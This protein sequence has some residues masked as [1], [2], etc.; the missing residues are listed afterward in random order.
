MGIERKRRDAL[1]KIT[2]DLD[3]A[4][5]RIVY[6][7]QTAAGLPEGIERD[8]IMSMTAAAFDLVIAGLRL[9]RF[10]PRPVCT[11]EGVGYGQHLTSC[12]VLKAAT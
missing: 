3:V 6:A 12:P 5:L 8:Q 10:T 4:R 1:A 11:C 9:A 2:A 7:E